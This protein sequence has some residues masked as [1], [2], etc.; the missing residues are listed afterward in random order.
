[1]T[2]VSCQGFWREIMGVNGPVL[3][4]NGIICWCEFCRYSRPGM[5]FRLHY[6]I[7]DLVDSL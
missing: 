6:L 1:M 7:D 5:D 4:P 3:A 2:W